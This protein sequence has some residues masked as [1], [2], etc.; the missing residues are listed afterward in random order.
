MSMIE[1]GSS[2]GLNLGITVL[3]NMGIGNTLGSY[4]LNSVVPET[5]YQVRIESTM[6][7]SIVK[8]SVLRSGRIADYQHKICFGE[9]Y[10]GNPYIRNKY[11]AIYELWKDMIYR[12]YNPNDRLFD[13]YGGLA[14]D[15]CDRWRCYEYFAADLAGIEGGV[16][17]L[18]N[19]NENY[20]IDIRTATGYCGTYDINSASIRPFKDSFVNQCLID[21]THGYRKIMNAK[22]INP[23]IIKLVSNKKRMKREEMQKL[24]NPPEAAMMQHSVLPPVLIEP[25]KPCTYVPGKGA[26]I[27]V[28]PTDYSNAAALAIPNLIKKDQFHRVIMDA[29]DIDYRLI[30][31]GKKIMCTIVR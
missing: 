24:I 25:T 27:D 18:E 16:L 5:L 13:Y 2:I 4:D 31:E 28:V 23:M 30:P 10:V 21:K 3:G 26:P 7:I 22:T 15:V 1:M 14:I 9:A 20:A 12:C 19:P 11:P 8:E 17:V 29:F 6:E